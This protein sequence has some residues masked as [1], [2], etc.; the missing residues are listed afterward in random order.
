MKNC[1]DAKNAVESGIR[2]IQDIVKYAE[3]QCYTVNVMKV[4]KI[5][6]INCNIVIMKHIDRQK[7]IER[8]I[9]E[10]NE[11]AFKNSLK[12]KIKRALLIDPVPDSFLN[13]E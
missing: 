2:I 13:R 9:K 3:M 7:Q 4:W 6:Q 10:I 1:I 12:P 8:Q 11:R 5:F